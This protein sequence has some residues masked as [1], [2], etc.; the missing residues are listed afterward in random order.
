M[1]P[2]F[3]NYHSNTFRH[4]QKE[5]RKQLENVSEPKAQ[6]NHSDLSEKHGGSSR[7]DTSSGQTNPSVDPI[8]PSPAEETSQ[9]SSIYTSKE[10]L[11]KSEKCLKEMQ[12]TLSSLVQSADRILISTHS[13]SNFDKDL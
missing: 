4:H 2:V 3:F 10:V 13:L 1:Y 7:A 9:T 12:H 8:Q 5:L 6:E 11:K